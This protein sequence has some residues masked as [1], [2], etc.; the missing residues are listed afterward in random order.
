[1]I[2]ALTHRR[3]THNPLLPRRHFTLHAHSIAPSPA[4]QANRWH[5]RGETNNQTKIH[6]YSFPNFIWE[7]IKEK[8]RE[9]RLGYRGETRPSR[10]NFFLALL[11]KFLEWQ[12][13]RSFVGLLIGFFQS[14]NHSCFLSVFS[15]QSPILLRNCLFW[16][17]KFSM[18]YYS[19]SL[20]IE[21]A[22]TFCYFLLMTRIL[23]K[24]KYC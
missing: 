13:F 3:F 19:R 2:L 12:I 15:K 23:D 7:T 8:F 1:M 5:R 22:L 10:L 4:F 18:S 16:Y 17:L 21:A 24:T 6:L 9:W 14:L 11:L 20:K